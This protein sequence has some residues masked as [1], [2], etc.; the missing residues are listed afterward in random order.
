MRVA[1]LAL[2]AVVAGAAGGQTLYVS[3]ELIITMRTGPSTQNAIVR[4]LPAGTRV[5][6]LEEDG[7]SGYVR[8][9][10]LD[11]G[12]EGWVLTQYL[13]PEPI[14]RERL[15]VAQRD[16]A[17]ASAQVTE[18]EGQLAQARAE[19][20]QT[21]GELTAARA[22]GKQ[23]L[24]ELDEIKQASAEVLAIKD[25]NESLRRRVSELDLERERLAAENAGLA[26]R[27]EREWFVVGAAVLVV[28]IILG[29]V[30][31]SLRRKRRSSW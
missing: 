13:T 29:L 26:T 12:T 14:A 20:D 17:G 10:A 30:L 15:A 4:N 5:E 25:Q 1:L 24:G 19:L 3:D 22:T 6:V 11:R 31:P 21:R 16:L 2:L 8:V 23:A 9:R 27:A 18:L 28:G 7:G